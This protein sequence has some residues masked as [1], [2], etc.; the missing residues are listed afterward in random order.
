MG[1][2]VRV[3]I[4][5][6]KS[7]ELKLDQSV[8]EM[9]SRATKTSEILISRPFRQFNL[10]TYYTNLKWTTEIEFFELIS[11]NL[12]DAI[13][14]NSVLSFRLVFTFF[15]SGFHSRMC[16]LIYNREVLARRA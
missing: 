9:D 12:S 8:D 6:I 11:Q 13:I 10:A 14:Q 15:Q 1:N 3:L 16:D 7:V 4:I 2:T 5:N